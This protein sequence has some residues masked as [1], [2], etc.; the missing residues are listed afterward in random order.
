MMPIVVADFNKDGFLNETEMVAYD[1]VVDAYG[2]G[3][4]LRIVFQYTYDRTK[5]IFFG[6]TAVAGFVSDELQ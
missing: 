4:G 3:C 5:S 6:F 2:T 1:Y